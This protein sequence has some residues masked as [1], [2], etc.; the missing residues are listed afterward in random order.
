MSLFFSW[1][2]GHHPA[3]NA[4]FEAP[5]GILPSASSVAATRKFSYTTSSA[6]AL[7]ISYLNIMLRLRHYLPSASQLGLGLKAPDTG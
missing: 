1:A 4:A 2:H 3:S 7:H 5:E 6:H